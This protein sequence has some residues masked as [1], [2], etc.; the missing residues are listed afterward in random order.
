M[1]L[2]GLIIFY[3]SIKTQS[4]SFFCSLVNPYRFLNNAESALTFCRNPTF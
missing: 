1:N 2:Y 4:S 3:I